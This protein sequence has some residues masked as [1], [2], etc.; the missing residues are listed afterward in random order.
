MIRFR[1]GRC[2]VHGALTGELFGLLGGH[3]PQM[4]QIALIPDEHDDDVR[5]SM[6]AE[7]LQPPSDILVRLVLAD[8]VNKE[9][10]NGAPVVGRCNGAVSLLASGI[11][12]LRLDRLRVDLDGSCGKLDTDGGLGVEVEF[13]AGE[14]AQEVGFTD[15]G[16]SDED[17]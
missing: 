13:V 7:L 12:N 15:A 9:R 5:V 3:C 1:S 4:S 10:T 17:H 14:S 6:I 8:I 16:V 11:P 2:N